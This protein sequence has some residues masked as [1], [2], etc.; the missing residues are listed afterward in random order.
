MNLIH[1]IFGDSD[2]TLLCGRC[3]KPLEGHSEATCARKLSRR[4]FLGTTLGAVAGAVV[5]PSAPQITIASIT[6][7]WAMGIYYFQDALAADILAAKRE[8]DAF[9]SQTIQQARY[10]R[11]LGR[12]SAVRS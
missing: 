11:G 8:Q 6:P 10:W 12:A 5:A 2:A 4:W 3:A 7:T 1:R 9:F